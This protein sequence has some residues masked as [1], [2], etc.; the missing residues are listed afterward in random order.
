MPYTPE[1]LE[2][3]Y[4]YPFSP[5]ATEVLNDAELEARR[6]RHGYIGT[7]HILLGLASTRLQI[8]GEL[9]LEESKI[10]DT[11]ISIVGTGDIEPQESIYLTPRGKT[12]LELSIDHAKRS[13]QVVTPDDILAGL[14]HED[15]GIATGVIQSLGVP[16]DKLRQ[17]NPLA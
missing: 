1:A 4:K 9:G 11:I 12:I 15:L 8:L 13:H 5:E 16:L 2:T 10:R 6:L 17:L 14:V 3:T 7:E